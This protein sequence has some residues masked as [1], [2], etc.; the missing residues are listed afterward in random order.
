MVRGYLPQFGIDFDQ[1]FAAVVKLMAFRMLFAIAAYY[2]LDIDQMD[3]KTAFLYG[4]IDQLVYMQIP[5]GLETTANTEMACKFLKTLYALNQA[6]RP[7]Y[8]KLSKFLLEKLGLK[9]INT[10]QSIFVTPSGINGPIV[11]TFVDDIKVIGV[12]ESGQIKRVKR[13]L[14]AAFE[15]VDMRP[16]NFYLGLKVESD[17]QKKTLKLFQPA[18]IDKIILKYHFDLAKPYNTLMKEAIFLPNEGPEAK[19]AERERYQ[20]M[21][22]SLMFSMVHTRPDIA[23]ATSVVSRFA[24][25][26]SRQNKEAV[27]TIMRYLKATRTLGI[28]YDGEEGGNLI[29]KGYSDSDWASDYATKKSTSGLIFMLNGRPVSWCSKKQ[30]MVVL[31]STE[32]EY[33][34]LTFAAKEAAR[35]RLLL[36]EVGLLDKESQYAEIKVIQGSKKTEQ[37][38]ADVA[39]QEGEAPSSPLTSNAALAPNDNLF[40]SPTLLSS[41]S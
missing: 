2:D 7:W 33:V 19:Q 10:D 3:V 40:L 17:R 24:K 13:K 4:I 29:I 22:G 28:K 26:P 11:S 1:T 21:T 27:K 32:A 16:I 36:T 30:A 35:M 20:G 15:I 31:S 6:A 14:A 12:K 9:R 38:K 23:I 18:Y 39:R 8:K 37:I 5:K 41:L 25:N 34:A